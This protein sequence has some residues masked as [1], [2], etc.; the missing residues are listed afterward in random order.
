VKWIT[1]LLE[2]FMKAAAA[3]R[4]AY[5]IKAAGM[6]LSLCGF[7]LVNSPSEYMHRLVLIIADPR[8]LPFYIQYV[9]GHGS[10]SAPTF[11]HLVSEHI[12]PDLGNPKSIPET[13]TVYAMVVKLQE[14]SFASIG[15]ATGTSSDLEDYIL[16]ARRGKEHHIELGRGR[17]D[18]LAA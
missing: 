3:L 5:E 6:D 8:V 15:S 12:Q 11:Q 2:L 9:I 4:T 14:S 18:A 13:F 10:F 1:E 16:P 7:R 17:E